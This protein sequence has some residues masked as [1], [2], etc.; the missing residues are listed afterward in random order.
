METIDPKA[1][2][3][4][5]QRVRGSN[6]ATAEE[7]LLPLIAA[8]L[9]LAADCRKLADR[10]PKEAPRLK[11]IR[12]AGLRNSRCLRGIRQLQLGSCPL[13]QTSPPPSGVPEACLRRCISRCLQ[14]RTEYQNRADH[15]EYGCIFD[16]L[17]Q[18]QTVN[19]R[20]LMEI[21]GSL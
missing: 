12:E 6:T 10:L 1:A 5:W 20:L 21:L 17:A 15:R 7:E 4:V 3:R 11:L 18:Q 2:Q 19:C 8:E 13:P 14:L 9:Q 16:A